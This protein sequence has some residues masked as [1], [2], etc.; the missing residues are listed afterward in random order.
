[1][2]E[3]HTS[4]LAHILG[5]AGALPVHQAEDGE[6][7]SM[8]AIALAPA[9]RHL[10]VDGATL[11]VVRGPRENGFRP[12]IDPLFRSASRSLGERVVGVLLSGTRDD[13]VAGLSAI[14]RH[15][16][17]VVVQDPEDAMFG[18]LPRAALE[19]VA[20]DKV[21]PAADIGAILGDI[22]G[23][24]PSPA[25]E[26]G[27]EVGADTDENLEGGLT[28]EETS[29]PP[30]S[31]TCPECNGALWEQ[32]EGTASKYVCRIGHAFTPE[33]LFELQGNALEATL[34]SALR[35]LEERADLADRLASRFAERG[36]ERSANSFRERMHESSHHAAVLRKLL[37]GE[38]AG[39]TPEASDD[40]S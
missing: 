21:V 23:T 18:T 5:R 19:A 20:V 15:G 22:V 2:P 38:T 4:A 10:L 11:R 31:Y 25:V 3:G 13:G 14:K 27:A 37:F 7:L 29:R 17:M 28:E 16:G 6:D 12:A 32:K 34:W 33:T 26:G 1:M 36:Q 30:S 8:G 35:A 24:E 9:D 40:P 39:S